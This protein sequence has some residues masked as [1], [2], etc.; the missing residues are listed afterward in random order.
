VL[1]AAADCFDAPDAVRGLPGSLDLVNG[2]GGTGAD[3]RWSAGGAGGLIVAQATPD[4]EVTP[5]GGGPLP[6]YHRT[7]GFATQSKSLEK[8][9]SGLAEKRIPTLAA[10]GITQ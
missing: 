5:A 2:R 6:D 9:T 1:T 10:G 7:F 8:R 4:Y 3:D